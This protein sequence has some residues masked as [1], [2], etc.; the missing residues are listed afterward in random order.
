MMK[1]LKSV[2]N[3]C[4]GIAL[5]IVLY[6]VLL[7]SFQIFRIMMFS[8]INQ[9]PEFNGSVDQ[10]SD[11][12]WMEYYQQITKQNGIKAFTH[13]P[14]TN[15]TCHGKFHSNMNDNMQTV[16]DYPV[17]NKMASQFK[18][19]FELFGEPVVSGNETLP[20]IV[21]GASSNHYHESLAMINTFKEKISL[22][23]KGIKLIYYDLG[24]TRFQKRELHNFCNCEIRTFRFNKYP[25]FVRELRNFS[26]KTVII[27]TV[28]KEHNFVMWADTSVKFTG[29]KEAYDVFFQQVKQVGILVRKNNRSETARTFYRTKEET[30]KYL[31]EQSCM[32]DFKILGA[33]F[34]TIW[35]TSFTWKYIIQP[36]LACA[37]T[38]HCMSHFDP[39][40]IMF[41]DPKK[42]VLYHCHRFDQAVLSII[43]Q[44]LFNVNYDIVTLNRLPEVHQRDRSQRYFIKEV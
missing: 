37:L 41:C 29:T 27:Y 17:V 2:L 11:R 42:E 20:V 30:F 6:Y 16:L 14:I 35:K 19:M 13:A 5:C 31:N 26:W 22:R 24:L 28:L 1:P 21:T 44:R 18:E 12:Y 32:F 8:E 34:I 10:S 36:W 9:N 39:G 38:E 40:L 23:Y 4:V 15:G 3:V 43:L 25:S 33:G 7:N